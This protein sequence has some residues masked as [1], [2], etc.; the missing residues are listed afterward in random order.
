MPQNKDTAKQADFNRLV[1]QNVE[2]ISKIEQA[3]HEARSHGDVISD[4]IA[5]FCGSLWFIWVHLA[6]IGGWLALNG[7][8][9]AGSSRFDPPPFGTLNLLVSIEA[10]FLSTFILISQNRLQRIADQRNHLD[11]QVNLLAE[12]E[13]SLMLTM[14]QQML[15]HLGIAAPSTKVE[16]L[17]QQT[18]PERMV[19]LIQSTLEDGGESSTEPGPNP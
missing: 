7:W 2:T 6:Y 4:A 5:G 17:Q 12:Q 10:I 9:L 16:T 1:Q 11:L 19:S 3:A 14:M 18:D 13:T 8:L 15:D